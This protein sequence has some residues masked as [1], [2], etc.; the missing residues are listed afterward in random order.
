MVKTFQLRILI[1]L[2]LLVGISNLIVWRSQVLAHELTHKAIFASYGIESDI[3]M[4]DF[5][6]S[7]E[8][9]PRGNFKSEEDAKIA[10]L[11]NTQTEL[12]SYHFFPAYVSNVVLQVILIF[13][14]YRLSHSIEPESEAPA[15]K[16]PP[17]AAKTAA[18]LK[19]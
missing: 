17:A 10:N 19:R 15:P 7:A 6:L 2:F 18:D 14:I 9:V 16:K 5:G 3:V 12:I 8:T 4:H 1:I 11:L 13:A